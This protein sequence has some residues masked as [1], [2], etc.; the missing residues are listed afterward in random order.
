MAEQG[1]NYRP[2]AGVRFIQ[3]SQNSSYGT[4][5]NKCAALKPTNLS[6][7]AVRTISP[8][9][10]LR[11]QSVEQGLNDL[12]TVVEETVTCAILNIAHTEA[13][14]SKSCGVL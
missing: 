8:P 12:E 3:D 1:G 14:K 6:G 11:T 13:P 9:S 2:Y 4:N 5:Y 7:K 10:V